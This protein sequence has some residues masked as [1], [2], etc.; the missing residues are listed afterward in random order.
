MN[1]VN[2]AEGDGSGSAP[3]EKAT[4]VIHKVL[5]TSNERITISNVRPACRL[6]RTDPDYTIAPDVGNI[7]V[8]S[9]VG[10]ELP[11]VRGVSF[12]Y[13][14]SSSSSKNHISRTDVANPGDIAKI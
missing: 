12:S 4:E 10:M 3:C 9:S 8:S 7:C 14:S 1:G 6:R 11:L 2:E 13:S 5:A